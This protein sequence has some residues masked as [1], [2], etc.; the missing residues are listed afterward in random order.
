MRSRPILL[1]G[2]LATA[3]A[4]GVGSVGR[5]GRL[6]HPAQG[7]KLLSPRPHPAPRALTVRGG[8]AA[9]AISALAAPPLSF[10]PIFA[11]SF[12]ASAVGFK[13]FI[14]FFSVGAALCPDPNQQ[15][16]RFRAGGGGG[17]FV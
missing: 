15:N 14:W 6:W 5:P 12:A 11:A 4:L 17:G 7:G 3:S 9:A 8:A 1:I 2:A 16:G 13:S 10:A